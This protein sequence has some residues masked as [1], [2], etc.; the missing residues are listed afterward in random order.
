MSRL[1]TVDLLD[2]L[3]KEGKLEKTLPIVEDAVRGIEI[4]DDPR[5]ASETVL[6]L[7]KRMTTKLEIDKGMQAHA[8]L[9]K[10]SPFLNP[11]IA[12]AI[13]VHC[14][15]TASGYN[16]LIGML[17]QSSVYLVESAI[18]VPHGWDIVME[19]HNPDDKRGG[20]YDIVAF[21]KPKEWAY[22][23]EAKTTTGTAWKSTAYENARKHHYMVA[24]GLWK[25]EF[26]PKKVGRMKHAKQTPVSVSTEL[27]ARR[28][29]MSFSGM[30]HELMEESPK[31]TVPNRVRRR[32]VLTIPTR[33]SV[34]RALK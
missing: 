8:K 23:Q 32:R 20:R 22:V 10:L 19:Y 4:N 27:A 15:Q 25:Y 18:L 6:Y 5:A 16:R 26:A 7:F 14:S 29:V 9:S 11:Q 30:I 34:A 1:S 24:S 28:G 33:H 21:D 3:K 31:I 17:F 13:R 12:Q 2:R